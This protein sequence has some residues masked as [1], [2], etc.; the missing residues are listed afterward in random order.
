MTEKVDV[1]V[2]MSGVERKL[3]SLM[4]ELSGTKR[5]IT[6]KQER[7]LKAL[8]GQIR[9]LTTMLNFDLSLKE[10]E[11]ESMKIENQKRLEMAEKRWIRARR[12]YE[13]QY[14]RI[15]RDF[16]NG[17]ISNI[18]HFTELVSDEL[19]PF[20]KIRD[21]FE[22]V[23]NLLNDFTQQQPD[24]EV[25]DYALDQFDGRIETVSPP[26]TETKEVI[27]TF[28]GQRESAERQYQKIH[29]EKTRL[30]LEILPKNSLGLITIPLLFTE[31]N[32]LRGTAL[33]ALG[34]VE[35]SRIKVNDTMVHS[36]NLCK[37]ISSLLESNEKTEALVIEKAERV[38]LKDPKIKE[39]YI[40]ELRQLLTDSD[41]YTRH[42]DKLPCLFSEE[43]SSA[44]PIARSSGSEDNQ[45]S[46]PKEE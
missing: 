44:Q 15:I 45:S 27:K 14:L 12:R 16:V 23:A 5:A 35:R 18:N 10:I 41:F 32:S 31:I 39:K 25:I 28:I 21:N 40:Q 1:T 38:S 7:S 34:P 33:T 29:L 20:F 26:L 3:D 19:L 42:L 13:Q 37:N 30:N 6:E 43:K 11:A 4:S 24:V 46:I 22:K 36:Q 9:T 2:D 17:I 8:K